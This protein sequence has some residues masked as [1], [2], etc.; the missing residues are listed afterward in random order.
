MKVRQFIIIAQLAL[1]CATITGCRRS[2]NE[3]WEDTKSAGHY[4]GKSVR[5]M[6]GKHGDSRQISSRAEFY[7]D[8]VYM[9]Q[10]FIPLQ[11]EDGRDMISMDNARQSRINPG[12]AGSSVPG[13]EGFRDPD[14][15][16]QLAGIFRHI[17]FAYN[18]SLIKGQENLDIVRNV[19]DY[20]KK[21]DNAYIFVEGHCDERGPEAYNF[22]LGARRSNS[23]RNMLVK[24]G[25]NPDHIFTISYGRERP[26]VQ[27]NDDAAWSL[28]R[29]AQFKV[30]EK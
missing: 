8:D 14:Q 25:V 10:E 1:A 6:G 13:I 27:G 5:T 21:H 23:V 18:D 19:A 15:N 9:D 4:V 12:E 22:A 20:M 7:P 24:E 17:H 11:D 26:I 30:Y 2:Q 3:V 16:A 28:N 29:R